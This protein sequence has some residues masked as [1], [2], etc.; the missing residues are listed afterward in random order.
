MS[1][2]VT[3]AAGFLG[4]HLVRAFAAAGE[5]TTAADL[6][7]APPAVLAYWHGLPGISCRQMDVTDAVAVQRL[8]AD[9]APRIV[10]HAAAVTPAPETEA[11][12]AARLAAVNVAGTA[13]VAQAAASAG[14]RR[15]ILI[16]SGAVYG[17]SAALPTPVAETT[18]VAPETLYGIS[19]VAAE[20]MALRIAELT[21]L[22]ATIL[23]VAALHGEMERATPHRPRPSEVC[24]LRAAWRE[25]R[26]VATG[27]SEATRDWTDADDA[28][29]AIRTLAAM[30]KPRHAVYNLSSGRSLAWRD[31]LGAFAAR[32]LRIV[33]PGTPDAEPIPPPAARPTLDPTRLSDE[34]GFRA[35]RPLERI[36]ASTAVAA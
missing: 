19:K 11:M 8:V 29:E 27:S 31:V 23:R 7:A 22:S 18:P 1:V 34:A 26:A 35:L 30:P 21:G 13:A 32:G 28:A 5:P 16:S 33:P 4:A 3:G 6:E 17:T 36:F 9:A 14:V 15:F 12:T 2:L 10:I 20:G 24:R 25:G